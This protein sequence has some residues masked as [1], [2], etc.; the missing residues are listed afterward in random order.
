M[1]SQGFR[2]PSNEERDWKWFSFLL[3]QPSPFFHFLQMVKSFLQEYEGLKSYDQIHPGLNTFKN[4]ISRASLLDWSK[5]LKSRKGPGLRGWGRRELEGDRHL[6]SRKEEER[7][8]SL[9]TEPHL[10]QSL[11]GLLYVQESPRQ[12]LQLC[13]RIFTSVDPELECRLLEEKDDLSSHALSA[14]R[15]QVIDAYLL[16]A[17]ELPSHFKVMIFFSNAGEWNVLPCT[18]I[19]GSRKQP[20]TVF[21]HSL[22][23]CVWLFSPHSRQRLGGNLFTKRCSKSSCGAGQVTSRTCV[24]WLAQLTS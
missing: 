22:H 10:K 17:W 1:A 20:W 15:T 16:T 8:S 13:F 14:L 4:R 6:Q 19:R 3:L 5:T 9:A 12:T 24:S 7:S 2:T 21:P 23:M 11:P 18:N